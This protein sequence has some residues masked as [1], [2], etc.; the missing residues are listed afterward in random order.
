MDKPGVHTNGILVYDPK[1]VPYGAIRLEPSEVFSLRL[2]T[3]KSWNKPLEVLPLKIGCEVA[4]VATLFSSLF[5]TYRSR[6]FYNVFTKS[7]LSFSVIPCVLLPI[8]MAHQGFTHLVC[9]Q[10]LVGPSNSMSYPDCSVCLQLRGAF[11]SNVCGLVLPFGFSFI[12]SAAAAVLTRSYP[13]PDL[14]DG[15]RMWK[16]FKLYSNSFRSVGPYLI[17]GQ[18]LFGTALVY[19]MIDSNQRLLEHQKLDRSV[20]LHNQES[21]KD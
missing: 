16:M 6:M 19:A 7:G 18:T 21:V 9:K 14:L 3:I 4:A 13:V 8:A 17:L 12:A 20:D 10:I 1:N 15:K 11:I 5:I 2:K